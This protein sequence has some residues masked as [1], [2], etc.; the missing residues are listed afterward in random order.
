MLYF[1]NSG[2]ID[3][4]GATIAGLSAKDTTSAIGEFGT[5]LKYAVACVLRWGGSITIHSGLSC[6]DFTTEALDFR[7]K[8]F[9]QIF[10]N[11]E[12]LGFTTEYGK[13]WEGW[14]VYRELYANAL[15]EGGGVS[16]MPA[17]PTPGQTLIIVNCKELVEPNIRRDTLILPA[18]TFYNFENSEAKVKIKS[19]ASIFY[20]GVRV[21]DVATALTYNFLDGITLTED[22][23]AKHIWAV[24]TAVGR[25]IQSMTD[26]DMILCALTA[27]QEKFESRVNFDPYLDTSDAFIEVACRLY[28]QSP[29]K[30]SR[31]RSIIQKHAANLLEPTPITLSPIRQRMLDRALALIAR[32]GLDPAQHDIVVAELGNGTL[33]QY[34]PT[35]G[36]IFLSPEVFNQGTKQVLSTLYE[37]LVHAETGKADCNYDMQTYLFNTIVSL[38]EEHVFGEPI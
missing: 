38:Y 10:M 1:H 37:E 20:R 12:P 33:G 16:T 18:N 15:D 27:G 2:E 30:W 5:G 8:N 14:Q 28:K 23:T 11:G 21:A 13:K 29:N 9:S 7:G 3:I 22:R 25:V 4:R 17:E 6:Y 35:T 34:F 36:K 26:K 19:A 32:M 24:E 31:L